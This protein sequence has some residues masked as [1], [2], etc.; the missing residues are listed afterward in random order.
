MKV[1]LIHNSLGKINNDFAVPLSEDQVREALEESL[2]P[3]CFPSFLT[4]N[5]MLHGS[6]SLLDLNDI[7][8]E[9]IFKYELESL[10]E[11]RVVSKKYE[12]YDG[13]PIDGKE[14]GKV[15]DAWDA[16]VPSRGSFMEGEI[17]YLIPHSE[18]VHICASCEGE[19][20]VYCP[21]C[22]GYGRRKP[23]VS[24]KDSY[25]AR[26]IAAGP[27][28]EKPCYTCR[29]SGRMKCKDCTGVGSFKSALQMTVTWRRIRDCAYSGTSVDSLSGQLKYAKGVVIKSE[30]AQR[31]PSLNDF[32]LKDI[33][34]ASLALQRRH[35][36]SFE[37][38][39][40]VEQVNKC[41]F[42]F[43]RNLEIV[44]ILLSLYYHGY[45]VPSIDVSSFTTE[46]FYFL[47]FSLLTV[48]LADVSFNLIVMFNCTV[49]ML[50]NLRYVCQA[51][52]CLLFFFT[53]HVSSS[54][55]FTEPQQHSLIHL[56]FFFLSLINSVTRLNKYQ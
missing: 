26:G 40:I 25:Y 33:C 17:T 9:S 23:K 46:L 47:S 10:I 2:R 34:I 44:Y 37:N 24:K 13:K 14:N 32:P 19:G 1:P 22:R 42:C 29:M 45:L 8:T 49:K 53:L 3:T 30:W 54:C 50:P 41:S 5:H 31:V 51:I 38:S 43:S 52:S 48:S 12:I 27:Q 6:P 28:A 18:E 56:D 21:K 20:K 39:R 15:P 55:Q 4:K 11:T 36:K 7:A 16:P 35:Q